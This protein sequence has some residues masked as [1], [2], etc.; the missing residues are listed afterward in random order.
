MSQ[1]RSAP[2][3]ISATAATINGIHHTL[4]V[5]KSEK[6]MREYLR[7]GAHLKAL[8]AFRN[9]ASGKTFGYLT[10]DVPDWSDVHHLWLENGREV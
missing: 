7:S 3:N 5:W 9:I 10:R 8:K 6:H 2:G 4:S 1:A